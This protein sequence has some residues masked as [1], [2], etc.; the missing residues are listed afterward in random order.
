VDDAQQL[1]PGKKEKMGG[2]WVALVP[3]QPDYPD[4]IVS[5]EYE[6]CVNRLACE[7]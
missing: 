6:E 5:T 1:V 3:D 4:W 7:H 2:R